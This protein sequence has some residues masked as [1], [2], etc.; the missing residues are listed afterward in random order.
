MNFES[1]D[2]IIDGE[3]VDSRA[4]AKSAARRIA[5][6][7]LANV[8]EDV[9]AQIL[10]SRLGWLARRAHAIER[11]H[12]AQIDELL[13]A[14]ASD[15]A[16]AVLWERKKCELIAVAL[17]IAERELADV[18]DDLATQI[19]PSRLDRLTQKAHEAFE[20]GHS[21]QIDEL[22]NKYA[23]DLRG[24][25]LWERQNGALKPVT[26]S[27]EL[28]RCQEVLAAKEYHSAEFKGLLHL[29]RDGERIRGVDF[30]QIE[31]SMRTI[32][33][34]DLFDAYPFDRVM[35]QELRE[36]MFTSER[37]IEAAERREREDR[38]AQLR[39]PGSNSFIS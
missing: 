37:V 17:R 38:E 3:E 4:R 34:K 10:P 20:R 8:P 2:Q 19:L 16:N 7:E 35:T 9:V 5:E 14:F 15:L 39:G 25:V 26:P 18:P 24:T 6:R 28:K 30:R 11:D 27:S 22:L 23:S 31:T 36:R 29:L 12:L 1:F 13:N 32:T 21:E 33:R